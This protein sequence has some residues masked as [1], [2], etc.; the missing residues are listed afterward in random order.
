MTEELE[1][2]KWDAAENT[3]RNQKQRSVGSGI[4]P[5]NLTQALYFLPAF[6]EQSSPL[7][8]LSAMG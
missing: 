8:N 6:H 2:G 7:L 5:L 1:A 3:G 4:L